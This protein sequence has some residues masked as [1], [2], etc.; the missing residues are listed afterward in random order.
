MVDL[1]A[2]TKAW[3]LARKALDTANDELRVAK[4]GHDTA[5]QCEREAWEAMAKR[6][7]ADEKPAASEQPKTPTPE[8]IGGALRNAQ[9]ERMALIEAE[10]TRKDGNG[11]RT[12]GHV[13]Y[14]GSNPFGWGR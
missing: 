12:I 4:A 5:T 10:Q 3:Y 9:V 11:F 1:E 2:L 8:E 14:M 7:E 6:R 13:T